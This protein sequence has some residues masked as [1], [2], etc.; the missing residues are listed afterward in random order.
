M[1]RVDEVRQIAQDSGLLGP[2]KVKPLEALAEMV[3]ELE[4]RVADLEKELR[5]SGGPGIGA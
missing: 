5:D 2:D 1:S 4:A 3:E